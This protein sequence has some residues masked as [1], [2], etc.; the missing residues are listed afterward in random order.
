MLSGKGV[1]FVIFRGCRQKA[2]GLQP[3][4]AQTPFN[5]EGKV[6]K[7]SFVVAA[8]CSLL[9]LGGLVVTAAVPGP[10]EE[11]QEQTPAEQVKSEARQAFMRGK[12]V[13]NQQIVEGLSLKNFEMIQEGAGAV[14]VM[15]KGQHWFV[16]DTP[17]YR[18]HSQEMERAA[19][20]LK[21]AAVQE[22]IEA[23]A[24]RYFDLTLTCIDCH[25]YLEKQGM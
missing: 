3:D 14:V 23:A 16:L 15:V 8:F 12:L 4:P 20:R 19:R 11:Q 2:C 22:N 21:E 10:Q 24:L 7:S 1:E 17:G 5:S 25:Q 13:S 18:T 6:M 9:L